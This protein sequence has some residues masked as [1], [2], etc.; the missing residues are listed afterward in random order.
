MPKEGSVSKST[1]PIQVPVEGH[2]D[3]RTRPLLTLPAIHEARRRQAHRT[4]LLMIAGRATLDGLLLVGSFVLAY[5]LRYG[6]ELGRDV[7][8]PESFLPLSAFLSYIGAYAVIT[9]LTF[10]MR[11]LYALPRGATWFD[12]MRIIT[13]SSLIGVAALTLG[14]LLFYPVLPSRLVFIY[15]G[16]SHAGDVR[17]GALRH[18]DS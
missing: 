17:G 14:A 13:G 7:I 6:L 11:G 1:R 2:T 10:Y 5:W 18:T 4:H 9:L 12:H 15:L 16:L 3:M 8:A